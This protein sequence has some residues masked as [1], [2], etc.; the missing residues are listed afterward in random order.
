MSI[1]ALTRPCPRCG[2]P[3]VLG[4]LPPRERCERTE[5]RYALLDAEV[6][7]TTSAYARV[8]VARFAPTSAQHGHRLHW[9]SPCSGLS[10]S[11]RDWA[12]RFPCGDLPPEPGEVRESVWPVAD[13]E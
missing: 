11:E 6:T 13:D 2:R 3:V 4:E 9:A 12:E 10:P 8:S 7:E 1:T 5:P